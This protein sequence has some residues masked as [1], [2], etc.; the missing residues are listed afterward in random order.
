MTVAA[1]LIYMLSFL[2]FAVE[3]CFFLPLFLTFSFLH[4]LLLARG[5]A[6][7]NPAQ[8]LK[9]FHTAASQSCFVTQVQLVFLCVLPPLV[10]SMVKHTF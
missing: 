9:V 7:R 8:R 1:A 6:G 5:Q 10:R 2:N 4:P 3:A